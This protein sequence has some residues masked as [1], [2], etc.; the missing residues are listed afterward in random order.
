[1]GNNEVK[2][3]SSSIHSEFVQAHNYLSGYDLSLIGEFVRLILL[4]VSLPLLFWFASSATNEES[5]Y[6]EIVSTIV[7]IASLLTNFGSRTI[8]SGLLAALVLNVLS[9]VINREVLVGYTYQRAVD[10]PLII[11]L[12]GLSVALFFELTGWFNQCSTE[13]LLKSTAWGIL[14]IPA[15]IFIFGIPLATTIWEQLFPDQNKLALK[16]P[17]WN[18]WNEAT[19]RTSQFFVF[20]VFTYLGA[21]LGSF[22]NVVAYCLPRNEPIGLRDSTCPACKI[23]I[24]RTDNL[25]IFSYINLGARCRNCDSKIPAR[26]LVVELVVALI[27]GSLFLYELIPGCK[28][29][30]EMHVHHKGILW[31]IFY[32]KWPA[33]MIYFYH[34]T[35]MSVILSLAL[36]ERDRQTISVFKI[37]AIAG[38]FFAAPM[39]YWPIQPVPL[40]HHLSLSIQ[41]APWIQQVLKLT[42]GAAMGATIGLLM[43]AINEQFRSSNFRLA[44]V[45][46]GI[47]LGWQALFQITLVF[48]LLWIISRSVPAIKK[49][50]MGPTLVLFAAIFIHHPFWKQ[51]S[52]FW[53]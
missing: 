14:S 31:V 1:M 35:L 47:A 11:L 26:Y 44:F 37:L 32:P 16:D 3:G 9:S 42:G 13:Q 49:T 15:L 53:P 25:P 33:I 46:G 8:R 52:N 45:L 41:L 50:K 23:K 22:L 29:I 28:N 12:V 38:A 20:A 2:T 27:F 51:I 5:R 21:C 6:L 30:P 4:L 7:L 40:D 39:A 36:M 34:A 19:F 43:G 24:S 48:V 17:D 10:I 18:F